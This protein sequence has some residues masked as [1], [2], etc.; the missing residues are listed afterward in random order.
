MQLYR[1]EKI[2]VLSILIKDGALIEGAGMS[3]FA[4]AQFRADFNKTRKTPIPLTGRYGGL[5]RK[6]RGQKKK[7]SESRNI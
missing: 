7:A 3:G 1:K 2:T 5:P 4:D 6:E